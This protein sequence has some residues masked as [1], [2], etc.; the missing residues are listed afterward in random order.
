MDPKFLEPLFWIDSAYTLTIFIIS[1]L[2]YSK[3]N[4]YYGLT[5][6]EGLK[7]FKNSSITLICSFL[8]IYI[9]KTIEIVEKIDSL[10]NIYTMIKGELLLH[11]LLTISILLFLYYYYMAFFF[12]DVKEMNRTFYHILKNEKIIFLFLIVCGI[13]FTPK[14]DLIILLLPCFSLYLVYRKMKK[15]Q[16]RLNYFIIYNLL[17]LFY[18][19]GPYQISSKN[20]HS[21][22][23]STSQSKINQLKISVHAKKALLSNK[24]CS[25]SYKSIHTIQ[26]IH[27]F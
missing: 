20:R 1:I 13:V 21:N 3:L 10:F 24:F 6:Y 22:L 17:I 19:I 27:Y 5:A 7:Y 9:L 16:K 8:I 18:T 25:W 14:I 12:N 4:N 23:I 26:K 11:S 15:S 2:I